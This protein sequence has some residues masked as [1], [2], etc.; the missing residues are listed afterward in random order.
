MSTE[1]CCRLFGLYLR[2]LESSR[3]ELIHSVHYNLV[4]EIFKYYW[5]EG[6]ELFDSLNEEQKEQL[7]EILVR[8]LHDILHYVEDEFDLEWLC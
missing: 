5:N 3:E 4:D 2:A 1:V 6:K 7:K 8:P